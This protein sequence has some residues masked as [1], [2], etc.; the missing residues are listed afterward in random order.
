MERP[1]TSQFVIN[2]FAKIIDSQDEKGYE[3][4]GK[5]IDE[6]IDADYN[7]ELMA[8]EE[9]ADL[10]KYLVRRIAELKKD[11]HLLKIENQYLSER[12]EKAGQEIESYIDD[13]E[14]MEGMLSQANQ[15]I[16]E[17]KKNSRLIRFYEMAEENLKLAEEN[18]RLK[19]SQF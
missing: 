6:A 2:E 12:L 7:W 9:T 18:A 11:N 13:L 17:M 16:K 5:S 10:Q 1:K 8:L 14:Q 4:Y 15:E 19:E 3:K